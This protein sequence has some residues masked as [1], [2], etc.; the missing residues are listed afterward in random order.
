MTRTNYLPA[1]QSVL[2]LMWQQTKQDLSINRY[3]TKRAKTLHV[4]FLFDRINRALIET[5][6]V[7]FLFDRIN[8]SLI[9][10]L[11]VFFLFDRINRSLIETLC[12]LNPYFISLYSL[13]A[14]E[15]P[16]FSH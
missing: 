7:F 4:F 16:P 8:R 2:Y 10:T 1:I 11:H 5:L 13:I 12:R 9:E 6:H 3:F 14:L 15:K